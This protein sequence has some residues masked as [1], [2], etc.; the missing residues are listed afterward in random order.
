MIIVLVLLFW[1]VGWWTCWIFWRS[2]TVCWTR[3]SVLWR[4]WRILRRRLTSLLHWRC[5]ILWRSWWVTWTLRRHVAR[6]RLW[7]CWRRKFFFDFN[8][9]I[10]LQIKNRL[11]NNRIENLK[12]YRI[13]KTLLVTPILEE[14]LAFLGLNHF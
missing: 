14:L 4:C 11:S 2:W 5:R 8:S 9:K 12:T 6:W 10:K 13:K 3:G 1:T 7:I